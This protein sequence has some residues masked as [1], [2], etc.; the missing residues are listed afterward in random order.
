MPTCLLT[1]RT[2]AAAFEAL[3]DAYTLCVDDARPRLDRRFS[4]APRHALVEVEI[5]VR[6]RTFAHV[7]T[8]LL[9]GRAI[10]AALKTPPDRLTLGVDHARPAFDRRCLLASRHALVD[11]ELHVRGC[12]L[13]HVLARLLARRAIATA[14]KTPP[15]RLTLGVDHARPAFD[16]RC[17][18][19]SRHALVDVELHVRG[20]AFIHVL[21]RLLAGRAVV[22]ALEALLNRWAFGVDDA[23]AL[24]DRRAPLARG[25]TLFG[26]ERRV[27]RRARHHVIAHRLARRSVARPEA[28]PN[29]LALAVG[30]TPSAF[31]GRGRLAVA[32][33]RL[34]IKIRVRRR[35][36]I[37]VLAHRLAR[38]R[39]AVVEALLD[40]LTIAVGDAPALVGRRGLPAIGQALVEIEVRIWRRARLEVSADRLAR[41]C[42]ARAE[43]SRH[44]LT[45]RFD[46]ADPLGRRRRLLAVDHAPGRVELGLL[47]CARPQPLA[48]RLAAWAAHAAAIGPQA[49]RQRLARGGHHADAFLGALGALAGS[50]TFGDAE[51]GGIATLD[52]VAGILTAWRG[53]AAAARFEAVVDRIAGRIEHTRHLL[54]GG[55]ELAG[56]HARGA[57]ELGNVALGEM[58]AHGAT[59]V[60]FGEGIVAH[61]CVA[62]RPVNATAVCG[63]TDGS[64]RRISGLVATG[65]VGR[66]RVA[67][68]HAR[69][70]PKRQ[71]RRSGRGR[72]PLQSRCQC[73]LISRGAHESSP[74]RFVLRFLWLAFQPARRP[75]ASVTR[76]GWTIARWGSIISCL[77]TLSTITT[78]GG[79]MQSQIQVC[80]TVGVEGVED[81]EQ[82]VDPFVHSVLSA[83]RRLGCLRR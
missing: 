70:E 2:I 19:A 81:D 53:H 46:D 37:H 29:R 33:T 67:P 10:A 30:D 32:H 39:V 75:S 68:Q 3:L 65:R 42:V 64:D 57:V 7:L 13:I 41:R 62:L 59:V 71:Q 20:C 35:A 4:L 60:V 78:L 55:F 23:P 21:A 73:H 14:L 63:I 31:G 45:A 36:L 44:R 9:A 27:C 11:V 51:V 72:P 77:L 43:A 56:D 58:S 25:Q 49:L 8:H 22:T 15:D 61:G 1:C 38:R 24:R 5:H 76:V 83:R 50:D 48:H 17:L 26:I 34:E 16:R 28:L 40:G 69:R 74:S 82:S 18:L 66:F 80:V 52:V 54:G 79:E 6:R 12:A 47:G